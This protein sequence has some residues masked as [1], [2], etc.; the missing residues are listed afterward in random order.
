MGG[1]SS[2]PALTDYTYVVE[3]SQ[4]AERGL[5]EIHRNPVDNKDPSEYK[6]VYED[7]RTLYELFQRGLKISTDGPCMGYRPVDASGKAGAYIF[8][9]C[10]SLPRVAA[11]LCLPALCGIVVPPTAAL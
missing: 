1:S 9:T 11:L 2:Q 7:G 4:D 6:Y 5:G 10:E 8:L 3:G